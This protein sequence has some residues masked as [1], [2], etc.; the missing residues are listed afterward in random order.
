MAFRRFFG[1][2]AALSA[3]GGAFAA[4]NAD[5]DTTCV[6]GPCDVQT[7][8]QTSSDTGTGTTTGSE[9]M[10]VANGGDSCS[11]DA[12]T[13]D[14][15]C[16][17]FNVLKA[18]CHNC[19]SDPHVGGAPIDL[20]TCDRFHE[21]DCGPARTRFRTANF[22][23]FCTKFMP[24]GANK[25]TDAE[26]TTLQT[27]LDQCAPCVPAGTGCTGAPGTKACYQD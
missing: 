10:P 12:Q 2:I 14:F 15:P 5:V 8:T 26:A 7:T 6:D 23:L 3:A 21:M 27:W 18:K 24:L 25:L 19:H 4:C 1:V 20:L 9:C 13:G 11:D 17:V 22:Y 16:D